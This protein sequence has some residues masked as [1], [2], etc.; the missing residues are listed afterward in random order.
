MIIEFKFLTFK[1]ITYTKLN[2][3]MK[4][5]ILLLMIIGVGF[6]TTSCF[7]KVKKAK[8]DLEEAKEGLGAFGKMAKEVN[9][10]KDDIENLA[11]AEPLTSEDFKDW[12]PESIGNLKRTGFTNNSLGVANIG[13]SEVTYKNEAGDQQFKITI[14]DGAGAGSFAIAGI[15]L[16]SAV[17]MEEENEYGYKKTIK[18]NGVKAFEEFKNRNNATELMFLHNERFGVT[19]NATGM[20]PSEVWD[21]VDDMNLKKL[22]KM[23]S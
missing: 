10:M 1:E 18:R 9:K 16:A 4:K 22:S 11:D 5:L 19:V 12:M 20:D 23:A 6:S 3:T 13:S 21:R 8:A 17:D 15:R 2:K 14:I 7:K